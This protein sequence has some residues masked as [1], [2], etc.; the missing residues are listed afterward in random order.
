MAGLKL[1]QVCVLVGAER[2]HSLLLGT[3]APPSPCPPSS[4]QQPLG[5]CD[6]Y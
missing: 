3:E 5:T 1:K 4:L 6:I 2:N